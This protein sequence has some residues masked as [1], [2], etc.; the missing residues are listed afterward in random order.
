[1]NFKSHIKRELHKKSWD[2]VLVD[3][4]NEWWEDEHWKIQWKHPGGVQ[5]YIQFLIDPML[6]ENIYEVR[7]LKKL[8]AIR[9]LDRDSLEISFFSM[10]KR[11]FNIKLEEFISDIE[12]YRLTH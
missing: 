1:M 2:I 3:S 8:E 5:I 10:T 11:K 4:L 9:V 7:A 6:T 12:D